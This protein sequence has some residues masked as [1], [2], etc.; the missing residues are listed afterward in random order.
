MGREDRDL[1]TRL[2]LVELWLWW[3]ERGRAWLEAQPGGAVRLPGGLTLSPSNLRR[4]RLADEG[5]DRG[6]LV[7][8]LGRVKVSYER[9]L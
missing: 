3:N 5:A 7:K 8:D 2:E 6:A 9:G 4:R 1:A